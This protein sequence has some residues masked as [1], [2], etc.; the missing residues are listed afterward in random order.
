MPWCEHLPNTTMARAGCPQFGISPSAR[1]STL[2]AS[3]KVI[4]S[5][6][7]RWLDAI[8]S[9]AQLILQCEAAL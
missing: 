2:K 5:D 8:Q 3:R 6:V 9:E 1:E 4:F 7:A